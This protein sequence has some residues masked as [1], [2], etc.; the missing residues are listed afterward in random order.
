MLEFKLVRGHRLALFVEDQEPRAGGSLV[1]RTNED[2]L[3]TAHIDYWL[4]DFENESTRELG[5]RRL[6]ESL[7]GELRGLESFSGEGGKRRAL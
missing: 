4:K 2:L 5:E 6:E 1:N 3:N 7:E